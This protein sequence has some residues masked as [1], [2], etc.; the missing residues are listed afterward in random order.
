[1]QAIWTRRANRSQAKS[2]PPVAC[3]FDILYNRILSVILVCMYL[4]V[5]YYNSEVC[6]YFTQRVLKCLNKLSKHN[7][8]HTY[9]KLIHIVSLLLVFKVKSL[10]RNYCC[11]LS[12]YYMSKL[13][14]E[15]IQRRQLW[16]NLT[17]LRF[18]IIK[19]CTTWHT[20]THIYTWTYT[21]CV[22]QYTLWTAGWNRI[23][24]RAREA[25]LNLTEMTT[26]L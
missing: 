24:L 2:Q 25:I 12:I 14:C 22:L 9:N 11:K 13:I 20:N 26:R 1:M 8:T 17:S 18:D 4:W 16:L 3:I 19:S 23:K 7:N 6:Y 10:I 15:R 21:Y 5:A